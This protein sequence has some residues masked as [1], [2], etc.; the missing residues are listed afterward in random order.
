LLKVNQCPNN[1]HAKPISHVALTQKGLQKFREKG[2]DALMRQLKHLLDN[3]KESE[4][5]L[6]KETKA[7]S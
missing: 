7:I 2:I 6:K 3:P 4:Y 1:A 5:T